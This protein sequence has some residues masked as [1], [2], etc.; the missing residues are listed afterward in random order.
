MPLGP[1]G[2]TVHYF[3]NP[4]EIYQHRTDELKTGRKLHIDRHPL[5]PVVLYVFLRHYIWLEFNLKWKKQKKLLK[6]LCENT[7]ATNR[8]AKRYEGG[9]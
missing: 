5:Y 6:F 9:G 8:V 4:E 1:K 2:R 7:V 3:E